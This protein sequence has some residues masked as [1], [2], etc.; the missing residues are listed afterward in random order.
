LFLADDPM[1]SIYRYYS[2]REKGVPV[3]G[4]TRWLR[5]PYRNTREIYQA[6]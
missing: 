3:A 1:Q 5:I 6:P 2:W 4:R